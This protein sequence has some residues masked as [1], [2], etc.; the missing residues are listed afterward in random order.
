MGDASIE[1]LDKC[2]LT[3]EDVDIFIPHQANTRIIDSAARRLRLPPEKVFVNAQNYGNTSAASIPIAI[4][5]A[6]REGRLKK[7]DIIVVVGF[8]A[9]L[10]WA[11]SV[12]RWGIN[13]RDDVVG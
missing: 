6:M 3:P 4:D 2:G 10:T 13:S 5:E 12:I 8:G 11:A 9:G 7:G 1:A